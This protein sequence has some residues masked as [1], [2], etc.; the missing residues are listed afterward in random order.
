MSKSA[1]ALEDA[2]KTLDGFTPLRVTYRNLEQDL[3]IL[4]AEDAAKDPALVLLWLQDAVV[5]LRFAR[6]FSNGGTAEERLVREN[7]VREY[8]EKLLVSATPLLDL[9]ESPTAPPT[10]LKQS[11]LQVLQRLQY[12]L[13]DQ[14]EPAGA[15][16]EE[17]QEQ[18]TKTTKEE[19]TTEEQITTEKQVTK[20]E[21]ITKKEQ[22]IKEEPIGK[23]T[24]KSKT[25]ADKNKLPKFRRLPA[26]KTELA[27]SSFANGN[28]SPTDI[29]RLEAE[30]C[31]K[32]EELDAYMALLQAASGCTGCIFRTAVD[33]VL[34]EQ[35]LTRQR[36]SVPPLTEE[37]HSVFFP[38]NVPLSGHWVLIRAYRPQQRLE[39]YDS[40]PGIASPEDVFARVTNTA[41]G[42]WLD[43]AEWSDWERLVVPFLPQ[44]GDTLHCGP[45][46]L[47]YARTV[48]QQLFLPLSLPEQTLPLLRAHFA[49][50]LRRKELL[51]LPALYP[52]G[53]GLP[54]VPDLALVQHRSLLTDFPLQEQY[55][56]S[57]VGVF[58]L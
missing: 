46:T 58:S 54:I 31:T 25:S 30:G 47:L 57:V 17:K 27:I 37:V 40:L 42:L 49:E 43:Q 45:Y 24:D 10:Q 9:M 12:Y 22:V 34:S 6:L 21:Q 2:T 41:R 4:S 16:L 48:A 29:Q 3:V 56:V 18:V 23:S 20:E 8:A 14:P 19:I 5:Q 38:V 32:D 44:Q 33:T 15:L 52:P 11:C 35:Q 28:L 55:P 36:R 50:E 51:P 39:L 1:L 53:R 26:K 7:A 13:N